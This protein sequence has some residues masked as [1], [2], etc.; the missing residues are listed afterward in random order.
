M[1][2]PERIGDIL[3]EVMKDI[4]RRRENKE[5]SENVL[6]AIGDYMKKK[7]RKAG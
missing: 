3:Q 7:R 1:A 5:H 4:E 6:S 2:E